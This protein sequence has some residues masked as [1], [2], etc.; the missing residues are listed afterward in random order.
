MGTVEGSFFIE[1]RPVK[2]YL[3]MTILKDVLT[4]VV[5]SSLHPQIS[6]VITSIY[7]RRNEAWSNMVLKMF[8]EACHRYLHRPMI[9]SPCQPTTCMP[10]HERDPPKMSL[11]MQ[12]MKA[13]HRPVSSHVSKTNIYYKMFQVCLEKGPI[14]DSHAA[15]LAFPTDT[16]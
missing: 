12:G 4:R 9:L 7:H 5:V 14:S 10:M 16:T 6:P 15:T 1:H 11:L 13:V 8:T 3:L 2:L